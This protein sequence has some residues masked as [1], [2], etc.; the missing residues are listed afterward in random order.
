MGVCLE[1]QFAPL[2]FEVSVSP[3]SS[4]LDFFEEFGRH[5]GSHIEK[6]FNSEVSFNN[7]EVKLSCNT[8]FN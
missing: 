2:E 1:V 7:G 3:L 5:V 4:F 8:F 6:D